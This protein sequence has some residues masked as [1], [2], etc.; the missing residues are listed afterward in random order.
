M[1]RLSAIGTTI[2]QRA[3]LRATR[4]RLSLLR[5]SQLPAKYRNSFRGGAISLMAIT[6]L[7]LSTACGLREPANILTPLPSKSPPSPTREP[8]ATPFYEDAY[9]PN[10]SLI[11]AFGPLAP[12]QE[13]QAYVSDEEDIDFFHFE[14]EVPQTVSIALTD[15]PAETDYDLYLV[16]AEEDILSGSASS[17]EDEERIEYTTSSVGVFYVLVLPFDNFSE[18]EP[19]TLRLELSPAPTPSGTDSYEPNDTFEQAAGPLAFQQTYRA[20]I[21]DE[22]DR[23]NYLLQV[24]HTATIGVD[25]T[26]IP[27]VADYDLFL[28]DEAGELLASS[29]KVIDRE[30]IEQYLSPGIYYVTVQ[31]FAGFSRNEPYALQVVVVGR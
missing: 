15:I 2:L 31:S 16:T 27:T 23:D 20:Y 3:S 12:G 10:D 14:I 1:D 9:E 30:H 5:D 13:Y 4:E 7:L 22:G 6:I 29:K 19:Y 28:Y 26:D 8:T 18:T 25:L 17:G 21:W 11:Q 24:D